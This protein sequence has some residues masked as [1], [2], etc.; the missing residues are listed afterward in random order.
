MD[1][2]KL[3][4]RTIFLHRLGRTI[5]QGVPLLTGLRILGSQ[6]D[7]EGLSTEIAMISSSIKNGTSMYE[8]FK[9]ADYGDDVVRLIEE[10]E[11]QVDA[12]KIYQAASL[13]N[14]QR[15]SY[16]EQEIE[17]YTV[18]A[19]GVADREKLSHGELVTTVGSAQARLMDDEQLSEDFSAMYELLD[20]NRDMGLAEA[21]S[22][23]P[24]VFDQEVIEQLRAYEDRSL[25][26]Y[27]TMLV[28]QKKDAVHKLDYLFQKPG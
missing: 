10:G 1:I 3:E 6:K 25:S 9:E 19:K 7:L 17:A 11:N 20:K 28:T 4:Q 16:L 22:R 24:K 2:T 21:M 27:L 5:E 8:I 23:F 14:Q 13:L 15:V 12:V 26:N 18:L